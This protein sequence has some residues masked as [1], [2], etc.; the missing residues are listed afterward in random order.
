MF[1]GLPVFWKFVAQALL[2]ELS[3]DP[4]CLT[5]GV[6]GTNAALDDVVCDEITVSSL[7]QDELERVVWHCLLFSSRP[8]P[9]PPIAGFKRRTWRNP[10]VAPPPTWSQKSFAV[11][12]FGL[13]NEASVPCSRATSVRCS[14]SY[15]RA[16]TVSSMTGSAPCRTIRQPLPSGVV[17]SNTRE[18]SPSGRVLL[19]ADGEG[20]LRLSFQ[21][22]SPRGGHQSS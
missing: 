18:V 12:G 7:L 4:I 10:S 15:S 22:L 2:D 20:N 14:F 9:I 6:G 1:P 8:R 16:R 5:F 13:R 19:C 17:T 3:A 11:F 21:R